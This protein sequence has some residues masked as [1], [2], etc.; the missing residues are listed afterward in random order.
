MP[1]CAIQYMMGR[2]GA[3]RRRLTAVLVV[4]SAVLLWLF[5]GTIFETAIGDAQ[6]TLFL[7]VGLP[8]G[9]IGVILTAWTYQRVKRGRGTGKNVDSSA[10]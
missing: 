8:A 1:I 4:I 3:G 2:K 6:P 10:S 5:A 9:I 7:Y